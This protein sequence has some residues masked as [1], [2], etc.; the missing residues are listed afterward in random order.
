M[1]YVRV[2]SSPITSMP[3]TKLRMRRLALRERPFLQE[4]AEV[5]HVFLDLLGPR[6]LHP[7]LLQLALGLVPR[8]RQLVLAV[9]QV[10]D[11]G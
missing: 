9:P 5:G 3:C 1:V 6:Q 2:A 10:E 11:A 7:A 8:C 4:G